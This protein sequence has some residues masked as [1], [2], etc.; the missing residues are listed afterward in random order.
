MCDGTCVYAL[1]GLGVSTFLTGGPALAWPP[2]S[3][4]HLCLFHLPFRLRP[5]ALCRFGFLRFCHPIIRFGLIFIFIGIPPVVIVMVI[6][7]MLICG[8][9][10]EVRGPGARSD[11]L[12]VLVPFKGDGTCVYRS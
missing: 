7:F 5:V 8:R 6:V 4:S 11:R 9:A 3:F 2:C 12:A 10:G 1:F